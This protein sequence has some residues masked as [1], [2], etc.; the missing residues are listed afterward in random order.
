MNKPRAFLVYGRFNPPTLGHKA[1]INKMINFA[2]AAGGVPYIVTTHT[3]R[4]ANNPLAQNN[5]MTLLRQMY[6]GIEVLGTS[7]ENPTPHSIVKLLE[8]K[9]NNFTFVVGSNRTEAFTGMFS[10]PNYKH[11]NVMPGGNRNANSNNVNGISATKVR[12]AARRGNRGMVRNYLNES[13]TENQ[14]NKLI[15]IITGEI[16]RLNN[17]NPRSRK[18]SRII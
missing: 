8:K 6:P 13:I 17:N 2:R 1:M 11:I 10:K 18:K 7:K 9:H 16:N 4:F 15:K 5:K 14:I 3:R 12:D